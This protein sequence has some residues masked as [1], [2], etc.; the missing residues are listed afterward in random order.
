MIWSLCLRSHLQ[1][2]VYRLCELTFDTAVGHALYVSDD[3]T[4]MENCA[5]LIESYSAFTCL[6]SSFHYGLLLKDT[7]YVFVRLYMYV[8]MFVLLQREPACRLSTGLL[9][10]HLHAVCVHQP[11]V[12]QRTD[13]PW[14]RS[15]VVGAAPA[16]TAEC[17]RTS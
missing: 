16:A 3:T 1:V 14:R 15:P 12:A 17:S 4:S 13:S 7:F 2:S 6:F 9:R 11:G 8:L 5:K 10:G